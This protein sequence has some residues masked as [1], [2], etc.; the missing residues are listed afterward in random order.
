MRRG[1]PVTGS[2]SPCP[3]CGKVF[4]DIGLPNHIRSCRTRQAALDDGARLVRDATLESTQAVPLPT[5]ME[6]RQSARAQGSSS[7]GPGPVRVRRGAPVSRKQQQTATATNIVQDPT[8]RRPPIASQSGAFRATVA[9]VYDDSDRPA[10]GEDVEF[11]Q[12]TAGVGGGTSANAR[13]RLP[14]RGDAPHVTGAFELDDFLVEYHPRSHR[15]RSISHFADFRRA[16]PPVNPSTIH[17]EP[18]KPFRS[19]VDFRFAEFALETAL[20]KNEVTKLLK[21]IRD[22]IE[23]PAAFTYKSSQEVTDT[24][25]AAAH[26]SADFKTAELRIPYL[27]TE[28]IYTF[29]YRPLWDWALSLIRDPILAP[30]FTW[31][32]TR[33]Y[34]WNGSY[35]VRFIDEPYTADLWWDIETRL[36]P[37]GVPVCFIIYADKTRLSSFG[38]KKGY[39]IMVRIANLPAEVRNSPGF[40]GGQVVGLLPIV[41]DENEEGKLTFTTHKRIVWH[42]AFWIFLSALAR[43]GRLGELFECGDAIRRLLFPII[44]ILASDYEE[45]IMMALIR[46]LMGLAPCPVCLVPSDKQWELGREALYPLRTVE[47]SQMLVE[48]GGTQAEQE[49]RLRPVGLRPVKNVFWKIPYCDPYK[50]LSFDRLHAYHGGLFSDHL[51]AEFQAIVRDLGRLIKIQVNKQFDA[52]PRWRNLNH[53]SEVTEVKFTDGSKY[54]DISKVLVPAA[55]NAIAAEPETR[56]Y[57]LLKCVRLYNILDIYSGLVVHTTATVEVFRET[58]PKFSQEIG[59]YATFNPEKSWNFPKAHTHQHVPAD[60]LAKG[61][62]RNYNTKTFESMHRPLKTAYLE[63][64]NFKAVEGQLAKINHQFLVASI[65]RSHLDFLEEASKPDPDDK[66][67]T[68]PSAAFWFDHIYLGSHE[69]PVTYESIEA[70]EQPGFARFRIRLAD[71]LNYH[72]LPPEALPVGTRITLR[73]R[74]TVTISK[75]LK[76]EYESTVDWKLETDY[77]RCS[78]SFYGSERYDHVI[79]KPSGEETYRFGCLRLLI[80]YELRG[81]N[82]PIAYIEE[83]DVVQGVRRRIDRDLGLCRIRRRVNTPARAHEGCIF[84][85][86]R[87]IVRGVLVMPDHAREGDFFVVDTVD[88]D[89]FLR[90]RQHFPMWDT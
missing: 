24:W 45:Q 14:P 16:H 33:L 23:K 87:S 72:F 2:R 31:H 77:L 73:A 10:L 37:G 76:V 21:L 88:G 74:D 41:E 27:R 36:P 5:P 39:P 25:E 53:F 51:F 61:V 67:D 71:F 64:T 35:W 9:E 84:I 68:S 48:M 34:K 65:I 57:Q 62:T 18:Y 78:P 55:Y 20:N 49:E 83:L 43:V 26:K 60:I 38:T 75:Y 17:P 42:D 22:I 81:T 4:S 90:M 59:I 54:E 11:V 63:R 79:Y 46:G 32:A 50:A 52:V 30:L 29:H 69:Y 6:A 7:N 58:L 40:G 89:M 44:L 8:D 28:R 13:D 82:Y 80:I 70:Q 56:G 1:R 19:V 12:G 47:E 15:P 66:E 86:A 3:E 85:S